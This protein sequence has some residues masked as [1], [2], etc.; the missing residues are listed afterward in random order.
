M[1]QNK[2]YRT[3]FFKGKLSANYLYLLRNDT[4]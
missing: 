1:P 4:V 3:P 2:Y